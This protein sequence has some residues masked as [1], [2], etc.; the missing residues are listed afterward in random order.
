[1]LYRIVLFRRC[2]VD[3]NGFVVC[4]VLGIYHVVLSCLTHVVLRSIVSFGLR[5]VV[6]YCIVLTCVVSY[7]IVLHCIVLYRVVRILLYCISSA[8]L[9]VCC[10]VLRCDLS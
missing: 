7:C 4:C 5:C 6:V 8:G 2:C 3:W 9:V 1:M 10:V